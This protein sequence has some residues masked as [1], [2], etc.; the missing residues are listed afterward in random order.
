[1]NLAAIVN[2]MEQYRITCSSAEVGEASLIL[3][4]LYNLQE[5]VEKASK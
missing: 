2:L 3:M 5:Q 4:R 1:M